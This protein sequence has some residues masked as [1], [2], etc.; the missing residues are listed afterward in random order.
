MPKSIDREIPRRKR[1]RK[2]LNRIHSKILKAKKELDNV[3]KKNGNK[4]RQRRQG[5]AKISTRL[6]PKPAIGIYRNGAKG[7]NILKETSDTMFERARLNA[8]ALKL[9]NGDTSEFKYIED[10]STHNETTKQLPNKSFVRNNLNWTSGTLEQSPVLGER[11]SKNQ[12]PYLVKK[13]SEENFFKNLDSDKIR[14]Q[15]VNDGSK[16]VAQK[17]NVYKKKL[18]QN[19]KKQSK[20]VTQTQTFDNGDFMEENEVNENR[21]QQIHEDSKHTSMALNRYTELCKMVSAINFADF[22]QNYQSDPLKTTIKK[23]EHNYSKTLRQQYLREKNKRELETVK[24]SVEYQACIH[25]E[26]DKIHLMQSSNIAHHDS[27]SCSSQNTLATYDTYGCIMEN[28]KNN[29][30]QYSKQSAN[31]HQS[32]K[33]VSFSSM[34]KKDSV[35]KHSNYINHSSRNKRHN[36]DNFYVDF[37]DHENPQCIDNTKDAGTSTFLSD[38]MLL[39]KKYSSKDYACEESAIDISDRVTNKCNGK[40]VKRP[41]ILRRYNNVTTIKKNHSVQSNDEYLLYEKAYMERLYKEFGIDINNKSPDNGRHACADFAHAF[42]QQLLREKN[43]RELE[44][45]KSPDLS[46]VYQACTHSDVSQV[47]PNSTSVFK[48]DA[49]TSK[50]NKNHTLA[51][52][53]RKDVSQEEDRFHLMQSNIAPYNDITKKSFEIQFP[54]ASRNFPT[55]SIINAQF[56]NFHDRTKT[57]ESQIE[58]MEIKDSQELQESLVERLDINMHPNKLDG[59]NKLC[60]FDNSLQTLEASYNTNLYT[61]RLPRERE[62]VMPNV[63]KHLFHSHNCHH[64]NYLRDASPCNFNVKSTKPLPQQTKLYICESNDAKQELFA[65]GTHNRNQNILFNNV[66]ARAIPS[67]TLNFPQNIQTDKRFR[68]STCEEIFNKADVECARNQANLCHCNEQYIYLD[69]TN[70]QHKCNVSQVH[71]FHKGAVQTIVKPGVLHEDHNSSTDNCINLSNDVQSVPS[72]LLEQ[73]HTAYTYPRVID[74]QRRA[75]LLENVTQPIKYLAV[76]NNSDIQRIPVY[77]NDRSII[78]NVP[79]KVITLVKPNAE[80]EE[81]YFHKCNLRRK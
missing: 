71:H 44:T 35:Q 70:C 17:E 22:L 6:L 33:V 4:E 23:L 54:N 51:F 14:K 37:P 20:A 7:K 55:P 18:F 31:I 28:R 53:L 69:S 50:Y 41:V 38:S 61:E 59:R 47:S 62:Q 27:A 30:N 79:L 19:D 26:D 15:N 78:E 68:E 11:Q 80:T 32:T 76:N 58:S 57:F 46:V 65:K 74:D 52:P 9:F 40:N 2:D 5:Q 64:T 63:R 1:R 24:S 10:L 3:G 36:K 43:K 13:K 21:T 48:M 42:R 56:V 45:V 73:K 67:S 25:E 39:A 72:L 49:E 29:D 66:N 16:Y 60:Q 12:K 8:D 75:V 77:I 34:N 81:L